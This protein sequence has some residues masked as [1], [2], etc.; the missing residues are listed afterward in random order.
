MQKSRDNKKKDLYNDQTYESIKNIM[1]DSISLQ[2]TNKNAIV[3][4]QMNMTKQFGSLENLAMAT[5]LN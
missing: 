1:S 5:S 2:V 3:S 4:Y